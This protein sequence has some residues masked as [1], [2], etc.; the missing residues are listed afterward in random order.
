MLTGIEVNNMLTKK[1][2]AFAD[3]YLETGNGTKSALKTYDTDSENTAAMI[4]S[5]NI[6]K[7]KIMEYLASKAES[8]A[9]EI[10][11]LSVGAKNET[12]KLNANKDILDRAGYKPIE[13]QDITSDGKP[14]LGG[15]SNGDSND[16]DN[17]ITE[18]TETA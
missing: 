18:T 10:F 9:S 5:T 11:K 17:Q 12:V 16:S 7:P 3:D 14:L 13:R 2:K 4:A 8:A 6:R 1:Q 15:L